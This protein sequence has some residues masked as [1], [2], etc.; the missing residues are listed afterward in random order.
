MLPP[1][2]HPLAIPRRFEHRI[3]VMLIDAVVLA[4][5]LRFEWDRRCVTEFVI[6]TVICVVGDPAVREPAVQT[7]S[8]GRGS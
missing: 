5:D 7:N 3:R 8:P 2:R 4:K 6:V 1:Q